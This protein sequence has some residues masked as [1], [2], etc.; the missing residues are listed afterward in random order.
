VSSASAV[1]A[2]DGEYGTLSEI[3]LALRAHTPVVGLGTWLLTHPSGVADRG[4]VP[5][6]NPTEAVATALKL[7]SSGSA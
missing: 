2:I 4:I 1:I 5:V 6:A 3:A 7:A